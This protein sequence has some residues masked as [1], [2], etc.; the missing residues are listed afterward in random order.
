M[1]GEPKTEMWCFLH[2]EPQAVIY[3]GLKAGVTRKDFQKAIGTPALV[4]LLHSLPTQ[5]GEAM[6]LP[7][8]RVHAIGA[9]NLILEIQQNSDTTYRVDDWG[10]ADEKT[11]RPRELHVE[12]ALAAI[13]FQDHEP[14]FVQPHGEKVVE[15]VYF[16][17]RR[18]Y[19]YPNESQPMQT[20]GET[21]QF[22]FLVRGEVTQEG[23]TYRPGS[24]WFVTADHDHY[25]LTSG[26]AGAEVLTVEF[27]RFGEQ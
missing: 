18:N 25:Q 10:R 3:A 6:F 11:G 19:L 9:G 22:H 17:V 14:A 27:P 2:T 12:Q 20:A 16:Y 5:P 24:S 15:C 26:S 7:S 23:A 21:F 13:N 8:G 4:G 1:G